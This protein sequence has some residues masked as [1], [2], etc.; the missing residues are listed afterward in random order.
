MEWNIANVHQ[1]GIREAQREIDS[2]QRRLE[3]AR[4]AMAAEESK[5]HERVAELADLTG[6]A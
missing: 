6:E 5:L 4:E 2:W 1:R 3:A